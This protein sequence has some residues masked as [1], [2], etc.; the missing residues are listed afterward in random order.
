VRHV[1]KIEYET[2]P[3]SRCG[4]SG[5]YSYCPGYGD[6]CFKCGGNGLQVSR[7]GKAAMAKRD[8]W[9][10]EN[11]D[12][13]A[14]TVVV[15]D[16]IDMV[17]MVGTA[18]VSRWV[19]VTEVVREPKRVGEGERVGLVLADGRTYYPEG[20]VRRKLRGPE[21]DALGARMDGLVGCTVHYKED[22]DVP[23]VR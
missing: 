15:G 13:T 7:R 14:T 2:A 9:V 6:R 22:E 16:K 19:R 23:G 21:M 5:R 10:A 12:M 20:T 4:G 18:V 11:V 8:A 1:L 3:C 17:D